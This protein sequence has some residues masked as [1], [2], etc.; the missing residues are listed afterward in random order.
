ML[1]KNFYNTI[2]SQTF[3]PCGNYLVLGDIYG[4]IWVF[5]LSKIIKPDTNSTQQERLPKNVFTIDDVQINSLI[6]TDNFLIVGTEGHV[7][8]YQWKVIKSMKECK[9]AWRFTIPS[10]RDKLEKCDVNC[11]SYDKS[12]ESIYLGCADNNIYLMK[13]EGGEILHT[14]TGHT[15]YLHSICNIGNEMV[16]GGED[17]IVNI[18]DTRVKNVINRIEPYKNDKIAR[19]DLGKWIGAVSFN[20]DWLVCGGGP[21]LSMWHLRT[22][23][24]S[25]IFPIDNRGIHVAEFKDN[26]ILAGGTAEYFYNLSFNGDVVSEIPISSV[27]V[28]SAIHQDEPFNVLCLAGS[29]PKIDICSNF[30]YRDQVLSLY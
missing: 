18:W 17:G 12:T 6:T 8:G 2:L 3:T 24:T 25:M 26:T 28:Y 30:N 14:F 1:N 22:L 5:H 23:N 10:N 9:P 7:Y 15:N 16:S 13:I 19:P 20:D 4:Q 11:M 29:S 27:T 21:R